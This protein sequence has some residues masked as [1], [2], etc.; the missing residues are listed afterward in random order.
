MAQPIGTTRIQSPEQLI[1]GRWY[2]FS[3]NDPN[4]GCYVFAAEF[5]RLRWKK[6]KDGRRWPLLKLVY[7]TGARIAILWTVYDSIVELPEPC[8]D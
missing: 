6:K 7:H 3:V 2:R 1:P 4:G 5:K 8:D